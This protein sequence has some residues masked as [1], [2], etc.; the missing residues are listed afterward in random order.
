MK[1]SPNEIESIIPVLFPVNETLLYIIIHK[2]YTIV[3]CCKAWNLHFNFYC[4]G[5]L[6]MIVWNNVI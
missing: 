1:V 6:I 3:I 5:A 4:V 2:F